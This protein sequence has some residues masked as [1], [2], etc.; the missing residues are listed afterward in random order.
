MRQAFDAGDLIRGGLAVG[1]NQKSE[2]E[3]AS[4]STVLFLDDDDVSE[5]Q[6]ICWLG[7]PSGGVDFDERVARHE[8]VERGHFTINGTN[9]LFGCFET[10]V[11]PQVLLA[12]GFDLNLH[13]TD[14]LEFQGHK[15]FG[16]DPIVAGSHVDGAG[17]GRRRAK[18]VLALEGHGSGKS[19]R[20]RQRLPARD[21]VESAG[22]VGDPM[23]TG[24]TQGCV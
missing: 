11:F 1:R 16:Q 2:T 15:L 10:E 8:T 9:G 21:I 3:S 18:D 4:G 24:T 12:V 5:L 7:E 19:H 17:R 6:R 13:Q 22:P 14:A 20:G 23:A